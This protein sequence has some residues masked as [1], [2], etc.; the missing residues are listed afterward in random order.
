L[1]EKVENYQ[2]IDDLDGSSETY[3]HEVDYYEKAKDYYNGKLNPETA[4]AL[5]SGLIAVLMNE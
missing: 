2:T 5:L 1:N 4:R 3:H